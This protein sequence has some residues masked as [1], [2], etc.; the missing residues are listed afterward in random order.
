ME[1]RDNDRQTRTRRFRESGFKRI[2]IHSGNEIGRHGTHIGPASGG[3]LLDACE[4]DLLD[5]GR[6]AGIKEQAREDCQPLLRAVGDEYLLR[7][8]AKTAPDHVGRDPLAQG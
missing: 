2:S 8:A 6:S 1:V 7:L 5:Y 3:Y 4:G